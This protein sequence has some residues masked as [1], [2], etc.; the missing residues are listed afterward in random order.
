MKKY[1][2]IL[3]SIALT[4]AL[5]YYLGGR[6]QPEKNSSIQDQQDKIISLSQ[7]LNDGKKLKSADM[8]QMLRDAKFQPVKET[9]TIAFVKVDRIRK[10]SVWDKMGL[11]NGDVIES[12]NGQPPID[13]SGNFRPAFSGSPNDWVIKKR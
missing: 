1:F 3:A 10:G 7:S 9:G 5:G 13:Q 4:F 11:K 6:N 2:P 8:I 12:I